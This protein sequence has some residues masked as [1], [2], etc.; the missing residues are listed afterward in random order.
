MYGTNCTRGWVEHWPHS[1]STRIVRVKWH[2][3]ES[4][5]GPVFTDMPVSPCRPCQ[6]FSNSWLWQKVRM[7]SA[8]P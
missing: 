1:R 3:K 6:L 5:P 7:L 2:A 4:P 8:Q